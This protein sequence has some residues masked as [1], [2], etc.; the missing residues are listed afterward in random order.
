MLREALACTALAAGLLTA[1]PAAAQAIDDKYWIEGSAFFANINTK[2]TISRTGEPGTQIN[3]EHDLGLGSTE[4]L[5]AVMAGGRFGR[6]S[7]TGE[8]YSLSRSATTTSTRELVFDGV[9]YPVT[10]QLQSNFDTNIYRAAL[11]YDIYSGDRGRFG[12]AIGLHA[13]SFNMGITGQATS[14]GSTTQTQAR[15]EDFLAPLPT[16]GAFGTYQFTPKV[17]FNA[18]LDWL[19]LT[20]GDYG[21]HIVNTTA[22][23]AYRFNKTVQAGVE[24]RYVNYGLTVKKPTYTGEIDYTF[25]GPA[26]FMRLGFR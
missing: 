19:G 15:K 14:G 3:F 10:T 23:L 5:P 6:F 22:Q 13:T 2:A 12:L 21:G 4:A 9:T 26:V 16:I 20:I 1:A 8:F 18:R 11:G 25:H 24:Y 7:V 17:I